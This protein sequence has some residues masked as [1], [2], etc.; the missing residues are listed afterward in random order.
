MRKYR[1]KNIDSTNR[2]LKEKE[3]KNDFDIII[4]E[5]QTNG[6]GRQGKVWHSNR[7]GAWFSFC[8]KDDD[9]V[10]LKKLP[11]IAGL[12]VS[13]V[14]EEKV[15]QKFYIKWPNDI[16]V[17]NKK[18]CGILFEKSDEFIIAGIGINIYNDIDEKLKDIATSIKVEFNK[19]FDI[20]E[21]IDEIVFEYKQ[22]LLDL[23]KGNWKNILYRINKRSFLIDKKIIG[24]K[25][26]HKI[27]GLGR[28]INFDC[29]LE[30]LLKNG[31]ITTID[32]ILSFELNQ[33]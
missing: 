21:I 1:F 30:I 28:D 25:A 13:K 29:E 2:Y 19:C 32:N 33:S 16:Y 24:T 20:D 12:A 15:K 23:E 17:N 8:F 9:S 10:D 4:A 22:I 11:L 31:K 3:D 18:I 14:L 5:K 7:G 27:S 6:K 26:G